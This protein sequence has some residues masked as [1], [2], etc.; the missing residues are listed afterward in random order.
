MPPTKEKTQCFDHAYC[1]FMERKP[2]YEVDWPLEA[3][4]NLTKVRG[5]LVGFG[6]KRLLKNILVFELVLR[7]YMHI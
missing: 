6:N 1:V 3:Y 7:Q 5:G 4:F 2:N